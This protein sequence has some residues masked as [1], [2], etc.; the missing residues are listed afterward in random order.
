MIYITRHNSFTRQYLLIIAAY[1]YCR[2]SRLCIIKAWES[3]FFLVY[4]AMVTFVVHMCCGSGVYCLACWILVTIEKGLL[5]LCTRVVVLVYVVSLLVSGNCREELHAAPRKETS[6]L[7][8]ILRLTTYMHNKSS[9][10]KI[11]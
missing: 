10:C 1:I 4:N 3:S 11:I 9:H 8:N 2:F 6:A 5:L 7:N